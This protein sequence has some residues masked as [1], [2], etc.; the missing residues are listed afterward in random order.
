MKLPIAISFLLASFMTV[1]VKAAEN[2][3][4]ELNTL[5]SAVLTANTPSLYLSSYSKASDDPDLYAFA[6]P[7]GDIFVTSGS[8]G[9][10]SLIADLGEKNLEEVSYADTVRNNGSDEELVQYSFGRKMVLGHV[11]SIVMNTST[12]RGTLVF[13]VES[14]T[15]TRVA[16][17]Y[18]VKAYIA[19]NQVAASEGFDPKE[20]NL[21]NQTAPVQVESLAL[22]KVDYSKEFKIL[23]KVKSKRIHSLSRNGDM[24][25]HLKSLF[26]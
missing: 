17:S 19:F 23:P 8:R 15:N 21:K 14:L 1:T 13:K 25:F 3:M 12:A 4:P 7:N 26:S 24:N 18:A 9:P 5:E 6:R 16:I 2:K 22:P 11:Y 20:G 10:L